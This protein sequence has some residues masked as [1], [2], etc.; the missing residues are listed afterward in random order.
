MGRDVLTVQMRRR[1]NLI[2]FYKNLRVFEFPCPINSSMTQIFDGPFFSQ[3]KDDVP[4]LRCWTHSNSLSLSL[5]SLF[6][7]HLKLQITLTLKVLWV[8]LILVRLKRKLK[9]P[10]VIHIQPE[11]LK[12]F[13]FLKLF[14]GKSKKYIGKYKKRQKTEEGKKLLCQS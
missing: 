12:T 13:C 8:W 2:N 9:L 14:H 11:I 6:H 1:K 5:F 10:C 7:T 3:T 4:C